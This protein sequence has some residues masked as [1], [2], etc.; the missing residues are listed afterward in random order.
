MGVREKTHD[1]MVVWLVRLARNRKLSIPLDHD[2][3]KRI[4]K[5]A[6]EG[7]EWLND[8]ALLRLQAEMINALTASTKST[9]VQV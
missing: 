5:L 9:S 2:L 7:S 4:R 8:A 6:G 1:M 3:A